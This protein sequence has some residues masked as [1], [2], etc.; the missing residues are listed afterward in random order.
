MKYEFSLILT[1]PEV[2]DEDTDKLYEAGC[3]DASILTRDG[4]TRLQ[5]PVRSACG[6]FR[7]GTGVSHP[8]RRASRP[9]GGARGNRVPRSPADR[10]SGPNGR[11]VRFWF[12]QARPTACY[13]RFCPPFLPRQSVLVMRYANGV[14]WPNGR[15]NTAP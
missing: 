12:L 14:C 6:E 13:G 7:W 1:Q 3:D 2:T 9:G 8:E 10:V 15:G 4:V 11:A 5:F